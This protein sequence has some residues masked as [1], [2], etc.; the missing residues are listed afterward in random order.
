MECHAYTSHGNRLVLCKVEGHICT[1]GQVIIVYLHSLIAE[2]QILYFKWMR[3][4][5]AILRDCYYE[6]KL[7]CT[8]G[9]IVLALI[10]TLPHSL[11][12]SKVHSTSI[13]YTCTKVFLAKF[14]EPGRQAPSLPSLSLSHRQLPVPLLTRQYMIA[15]ATIAD[16]KELKEQVRALNLLILTLPD[17]HQ[18][19]LKV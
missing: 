10:H 7:N 3:Y 17:L 4:R 19:V 9:P 5:R 18:R 11:L 15:F 1:L 8:L 16:I 13:N 12:I 2:H 14:V 6:R